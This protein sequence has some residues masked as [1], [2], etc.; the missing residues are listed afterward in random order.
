MHRALRLT[1]LLLMPVASAC[2]GGDRAS[3]PAAAPN[4]A[5][6]SRA[7]ETWL[8]LVDGNIYHYVTRENADSGMLV[9]RI[10]RTDATHGEL[11]TGRVVKRLVYAPD[12]VRYDG[13][14][15]IVQTPVALGSSW[16][17][18][19]DGTT[20][21]TGVDGAVTVPA[22]TFAGCVVTTEEGGRVPGARYTTT[23]CPNVGIVLLE[24]AAPGT[25]LRAEL[26][27]YGPPVVIQ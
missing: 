17:G 11:H 24:V 14:A 23:L 4:D 20:T 18:E 21:I 7:A 3:S 10:V 6:G 8:P 9:T 19:H 1:S 2:G 15:L 12:G 13:G 27:S 25:T 26:K 22:G 5:G 16:R